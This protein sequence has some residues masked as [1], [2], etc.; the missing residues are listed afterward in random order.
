[1]FYVEGFLFSPGKDQR[2]LMRELETIIETFR[3]ATEKGASS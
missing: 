2:E 1:L 3:T